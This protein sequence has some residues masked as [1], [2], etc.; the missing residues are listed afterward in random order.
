MTRKLKG[1][2]ALVEETT[3][4][5][6]DIEAVCVSIED[7]LRENLKLGVHSCTY[8]FHNGTEEVQ[9]STAKAVAHAMTEA[10]YYC[11]V[12]HREMNRPANEARWYV[13]VSVDVPRL[14]PW[15]R[16]LNWMMMKKKKQ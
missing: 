13:K 3:R 2:A 12:G 10:G 1:R 4:P 5:L 7:R 15:R 9:R 11:T 14:S 6:Y 16:L 8:V